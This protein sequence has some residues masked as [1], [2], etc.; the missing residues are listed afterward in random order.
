MFD[1]MRCVE[2]ASTDSVQRTDTEIF[3]DVE[4]KRRRTRKNELLV[5]GVRRAH[6]IPGSGI[7]R[8]VRPRRDVVG[9]DHSTEDCVVGLLNRID[10]LQIKSRVRRQRKLIGDVETVREFRARIERRTKRIVGT[11][12]KP[13]HSDAGI[14]LDSTTDGSAPAE[15]TVDFAT[16]RPVLHRNITK[17]VGVEA[18][19]LVLTFRQHEVGRPRS[20]VTTRGG[21]QPTRSDRLRCNAIEN[22]GR[23]NRSRRV[24]TKERHAETQ[25]FQ[26]SCHVKTPICIKPNGSN[27]RYYTLLSQ[28]VNLFYTSNAPYFLCLW[29]CTFCRHPPRDFWG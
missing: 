6:V 11:D 26:Q 28:N 23:V 24:T 3:G 10:L 21:E 2:S 16:D 25:T 13:I 4:R 29:V 7:E 5:V 1:A 9:S 17:D 14:V 27:C 12:A 19:A 20:G 15:A 22:I 8:Q 18:T